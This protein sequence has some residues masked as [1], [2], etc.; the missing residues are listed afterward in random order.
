MKPP[1]VVSDE[2]PRQGLREVFWMVR[3]CQFSK[4]FW[5]REASGSS[6]ERSFACQDTDFR[7]SRGLT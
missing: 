7:K 2:V 3:S 5:V 1:V 6:M 4:G